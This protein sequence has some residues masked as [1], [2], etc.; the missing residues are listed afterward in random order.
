[1]EINKQILTLFAIFCIIASAGI[2]CAAD[3]GGYTGGNHHNM[4]GVDGSQ[5]NAHEVKVLEPGNGLLLENQTAPVHVNATGNATSHIAAN[6]TAN[7]TGNATSH[8]ATNVTN[9]TG[10]ATHANATHSLPVAGNPIVLLL[11]G[12]A[13]VGGYIIL[14]RN[15]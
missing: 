6:A 7:A 9:T 10:N 3:H 8:V 13:L 15:P 4:N 11:A 12:T 14:R 2:V 5:Y 1:M